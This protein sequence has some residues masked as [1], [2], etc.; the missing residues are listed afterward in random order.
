MAKTKTPRI[1]AGDK[2]SLTDNEGSLIGLVRRQQ[3][4][5]AYQLYKIYET[6]P[7]SSFNTSKGSL[8]PLI[9]RLRKRG[10][11][12]AESVAGDKRN[13]E[14]LT[15]TSAG[16][17]AVAAWARTVK[18]SDILLDD[19]LRTKLLSLDLL[20]REEQTRWVVEAKAE[21]TRKMETVE[22]Y[23]Q[24]VSVPFQ[25]FVHRSA[26]AALEAKMK[27]LDELLYHFVKGAE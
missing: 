26:I 4:V 19:P 13:T 14:Q 11:I 24:A 6:S 15:C 5:T 10:L 23:N 20:T 22:A 2:E 3:P 27:W 18:T 17:K 16:V 21:V 8:Y 7:V 12:A 1:S 25:Q 9:S